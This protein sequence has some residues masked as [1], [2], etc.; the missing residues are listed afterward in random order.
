MLSWCSGNMLLVVS[1]NA[2]ASA[3]SWI[4]L[5]L[6][7]SINEQA[8]REI[9][10]AL[11]TFHSGSSVC[12]TWRDDHAALRRITIRWRCSCSRSRTRPVRSQ[13]SD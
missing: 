10:L 2:I 12:M 4:D 11:A 7:S 3:G 13:V 9:G 5:E 8:P 1:P 6:P